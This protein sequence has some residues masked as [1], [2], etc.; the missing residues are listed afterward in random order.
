MLSQFSPCEWRVFWLFLLSLNK[1]R[2]IRY[3][4][5]LTVRSGKKSQYTGLGNMG[6]LEALNDIKLIVNDYAYFRPIWYH[7]DHSDIPYSSKP[8]T[9]Q[10]LLLHF[11][12]Q[13][14]SSLYYA[15]KFQ[16]ECLTQRLRAHISFFFT[17]GKY[18]KKSILLMYV[19]MFWG[20]NSFNMLNKGASSNCIYHWINWE[21]IITYLFVLF[22]ILNAFLVLS[23]LLR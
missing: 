6:T 19:V 21:K 5:R 12:Q 22:A 10:G 8:V 11:L 2:T 3:Q 23:V 1:L 9:W 16:L 15:A 7:S 18:K 13:S 4:S 17:V 20:F 14:G